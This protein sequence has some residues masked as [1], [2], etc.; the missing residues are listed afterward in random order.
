M[1]RLQENVVCLFISNALFIV[2][3]IEKLHRPNSNKTHYNY[4]TLGI[5]GLLFL[6]M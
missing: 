2:H 3:Y 6:L 1:L 4:L 5:V